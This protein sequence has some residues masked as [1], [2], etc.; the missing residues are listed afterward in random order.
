MISKNQIKFIRSLQTSKFRQIHGQY[1]VEGEKMLNELLN[2]EQNILHI[3]GLL[4]W[5]KQHETIIKK[6]QVE[7]TVV[8]ESELAQI[9]TLTTPNKVLAVVEGTI[10]AFET[11]SVL[12]EGIMLF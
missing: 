7:Y 3:Y 2:S 4:D 11:N 1:L 8:S 12:E 6:K 9:S 5:V 10:N